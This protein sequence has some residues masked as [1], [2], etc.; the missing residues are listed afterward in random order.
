MYTRIVRRVGG[1]V[2]V[3]AM[4]VAA[5]LSSPAYADADVSCGDSN[6]P[7]YTGTLDL[8]SDTYDVYAKLGRPSQIASVSA[9]AQPAGGACQ[10]LGEATASGTTWQKV[11]AVRASGE[12][13]LQLS[14]PLLADLPSANRPSL[15]LVPR[16]HAIC[17]PTDE[18]R[19]TI[20]G[21]SA[22]IRPAGTNLEEDALRIV[23][24]DSVDIA[25]VTKV[26][27]YADNELLYETKTLE[28]FKPDDIPYYAN[29]LVRVLYYPSGQTAVI[30]SDAP[31][32]SGDT[33]GATIM[34]YAKKY[35]N[36]LKLIGAVV[37]VVA[38]LWVALFVIEYRIKR[39]QWRIAHGFLKQAAA[40]VSTPRQLKWHS[41]IRLTARYLGWTI[42]G[43]AAM[44]GIVLTVNAFFVQIGTVSGDSMV[45]ALEDGQQIV[46]NKTPV[47]AA[48]FNHT[49]Y[50]PGRGDVVVASP[51]F[52][53]VDVSLRQGDNSLIVKRVVGL[54][55]ERIT[56]KGQRVTVYNEAH[57]NGFDPQAGASWAAAIQ[58][59]ASD[60]DVD[61][62]LG[63]NELFL[64]GDN[65]P[66]SIDSRMNGPISTSQ[67]VG[68]VGWQ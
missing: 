20:A 24:V 41:R 42:I 46:I 65:R 29:K 28:A 14:S 62:T 56:V 35:Q 23:R 50:V 64:M 54:P 6:I 11:G 47:T 27:Y 43:T 61:V 37:A 48:R 12:T 32:V 21:Q 26:Q 7:S 5:S 31:A 2:A 52:G 57:P 17:V 25:Q 18:C 63:E 68:V 53:T 16:S 44:T 19:A 34:R 66:V 9:Y 55:G 51:N 1:V 45:A 33:F 8:P 39:R 3:T 22:S 67:V 40:P 4:V 60:D 13:F 38:C 59:E 15:M 36:T 30:T 10:T 58:A 49:R